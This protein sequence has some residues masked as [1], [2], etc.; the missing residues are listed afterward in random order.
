MDTPALK[1]GFSAPFYLSGTSHKKNFN[2]KFFPV[3]FEFLVPWPQAVAKCFVAILR[4]SASFNA[5]AMAK[6]YLLQVGRCSTV[7]AR[8]VKT[9][10]IAW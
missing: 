8:F 1:I 7:Y 6:N 10:Y 3:F 4:S 2:S 9:V 5:V